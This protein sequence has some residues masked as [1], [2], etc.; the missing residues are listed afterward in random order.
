MKCSRL[1]PVIAAVLSVFLMIG[2]GVRAAGDDRQ[3]GVEEFPKPIITGLQDSLEDRPHPN[4]AREKED[5]QTRKDGWR[6]P[7][8]ATPSMV[9]KKEAPVPKVVTDLFTSKPTP[10]SMPKMCL[11]GQLS[12]SEGD[13]VALLEI[14]GGGVHIVR[15]GDTV[16]LHELGI[17]SV[18]LVKKIG[19]L[20]LVVESGSLGQLIIVR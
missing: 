15:E 10:L 16:G 2:Q 19:R 6:N 3:S 13:A 18:L 17:D 11:R 5:Y 8:S 12:S 7:F 1:I 20:H 9:P 4:G 14:A